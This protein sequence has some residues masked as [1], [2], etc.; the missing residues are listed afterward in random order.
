MKELDKINK[1][2]EERREMNATIADFKKSI[3]ESQRQIKEIKANLYLKENEV[4]LLTINIPLLDLRRSLNKYTNFHIGVKLIVDLPA[5]EKH[6]NIKNYIKKFNKE[7]NATLEMTSYYYRNLK[8]HIYSFKTTVIPAQL[9]CASYYDRC[10]DTIR[11]DCE[12]PG[13]L[14]VQ[15][16]G[17]D[18]I[19]DSTLQK[20]VNDYACELE[21][22]ANDDPNRN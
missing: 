7:Q 14:V 11:V 1:F 19:D 12:Y 2:L 22:E 13:D 15:L 6:I 20:I 5:P 18:I 10:D 21:S 3:N 9:K 8:D 4:E 16:S 17:S